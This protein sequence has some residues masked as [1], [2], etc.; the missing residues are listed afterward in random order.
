MGSLLM[1][2]PRELSTFCFR[3]YYEGSEASFTS[4]AAKKR[5][6]P[7]F[8]IDDSLAYRLEG[9]EFEDWSTWAPAGRYYLKSVYLVELAKRVKDTNGRFMR[10]LFAVLNRHN[11]ST[12]AL[13]ANGRVEAVA[14]SN[15]PRAKG[16][17]KLDLISLE[18]VFDEAWTRAIDAWPMMGMTFWSCS[19]N[20]WYGIRKILHKYIDFNV[21]LPILGK[22]QHGWQPDT[23]S[24]IHGEHGYIDEVCKAR[25]PVYVWSTGNLK[26]ALEYKLNAYAVGSPWLY[27]VEEPLPARGNTLL[28]FPTHSYREMKIKGMNWRE[29]TR[30]L[31]LVA[32]KEGFDKVAISLHAEDYTEQLRVELLNYGVEAITFGRTM[33]EDYFYRVRR[34][35]RS[36]RA[37]TSDRICSS[38]FY[39]LYENTPVFLKGRP[40]F[41]DPPD[42]VDTDIDYSWAKKHFPSLLYYDGTVKHRDRALLELG[43]EN[44]LDPIELRKLLYG[45]A[46][47]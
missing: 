12:T 6:A 8:V 1:M 9:T 15:S 42:P 41:R 20:E 16:M 35:I 18:A 44:K 10:G 17:G 13:V 33:V 37:V 27:L 11:F 5:V 7:A 22:V 40:I 36:V 38:V 3:K 29:Y 30:E 46:G 28:A 39:A 25:A 43:F 2:N 26:K 45:W 21:D 14:Y 19:T 34:S 23:V 4:I 32:K 24:G 31:L 47:L